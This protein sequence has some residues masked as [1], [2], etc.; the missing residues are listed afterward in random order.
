MVDNTWSCKH[1]LKKQALV[2]WQH[3]LLINSRGTGATKKDNDLLECLHHEFYPSV[4][5]PLPWIIQYLHCKDWR[6]A[7]FYSPPCAFISKTVRRCLNIH[8]SC[9]SH[10]NDKSMINIKRPANPSILFHHDYFLASQQTYLCICQSTRQTGR[11]GRTSKVSSWCQ[12]AVCNH[13]IQ[14]LPSVSHFCIWLW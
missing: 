4:R 14:I 10:T 9:S 12:E 3:E 11:T 1:I 7:P 6:V 8:P 5:F 2:I 13:F